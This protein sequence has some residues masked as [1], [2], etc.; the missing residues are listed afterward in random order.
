MDDIEKLMRAKIPEPDTGIEIKRTI[1]DICSPNEHCGID[2]Y[3][4][5]GKVIK[6]EGTKEHPQNRGYLC[7]K[8]AASRQYI[9]R[10]DRIKTPLR[11]VGEKGEGAFEPVSWD[12]AYKEIA[13]N[14]NGVK[15]QYGSDSVAFVTGFSKWYRQVF[16]R[17]AYSFGSVNYATEGSCC[18]ETTSMAWD[19]TTGTF[20][21]PDIGN[22]KV[23]LGWALSPYYSDHNMAAGIQGF[24][25][26]GGK[27]IIV[28]PRITPATQNF[29]DIHLRI[30]PGTDGALALGM[31]KLIIENGWEDRAFIE[32]YT[33]G[34][35]DYAAYAARFDLDTVERIT[36][37]KAEDICRATE[38]FATNKPA[39]IHQSAAPL[40]HHINGFQ[41]YRAII[42]LAGLTG[43][44]DCPG[45]LFPLVMTY[46]HQGAGFRTK[47]NEFVNEVHPGD[48]ARRIGH[49]RFP[50]WDAFM[51]EFQM[52]ALAD[53]IKSGKPYP[54]KAVYGLGFN[55][56]MLPDSLGVFD[57]LKEVFFV[58][59]DLFLTDTAR[60]ADI[61]LP[62]CSSFER[63]D[64]KVYPGGFSLFTKPAIEPLYDS[65]SD[66]DIL[67]ELSSYL[68]LDDPLLSQGFEACVDWM[69]SDTGL[70]VEELKKSDL[71]VMTPAAKPPLIGGMRENGFWTPTK[72]FEF[73]SSVIEN[74]PEGSGL[75]A[76]P[77]YKD[78]LADST[79]QYDFMLTSGVRLPNTCHSRLHDVPWLRSLKPAPMAEI[80]PEDA[81]R[82]GVE[83]GDTIEIYN[84]NGSITVQAKPTI[85]VLKGNIHLGHSYRECNA[86]DI[87]GK[88]HLDPYTGYPGF[89]SIGCN[90]RKSE[91]C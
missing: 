70:T 71:P 52:V 73:K 30:R 90:V 53:Q 65:K 9:Y 1:C 48:W 2:A 91:V 5:D 72:K 43:N 40:G 76:L 78:P 6:V 26:H 54:V 36:G 81:K 10:E 35:E 23:Y 13:K 15:E 63:H 37:V 49:G 7:T 28:D 51:D 56:R 84:E 60:Y 62:C 18:F 89:K 34:Y 88:Q 46:M 87:A 16:K 59:T 55:A 66:V 12:E 42:C 74:L 50:V 58:D 4:K 14:L 17:F 31:A 61:V 80:N 64:Y 82:L 77:T 45:G 68:G 27:V 67:C 3:V 22:S 20:S 32:K 33:Y 79:E 41:N 8:G 47:E 75:D 11:R 86:N 69:I 19:A 29:A 57:A 25:E 24:K 83:L 38:L 21:V 44:Y 39:S 85:S